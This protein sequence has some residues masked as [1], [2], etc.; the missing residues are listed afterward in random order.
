MLHSKINF[1]IFCQFKLQIPQTES[2]RGEDMFFFPSPTMSSK[3]IVNCMKLVVSC[4]ASQMSTSVLW[5]LNIL[6]SKVSLW[7]YSCSLGCL[8]A[9]FGNHSTALNPYQS[10]LTYSM[11]SLRLP[12]CNCLFLSSLH[13]LWVCVSGAWLSLLC[14]HQCLAQGRTQL[15]DVSHDLGEHRCRSHTVNSWEMF[16]PPTHESS[17]SKCVQTLGYK[18]C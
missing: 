11:S 10:K 7:I 14:P 6:Y 13:L 2:K 5:N 8:G 9:Q 16:H 17:Q 1:F 12:C 18:Y 15:K 4:N 3:A